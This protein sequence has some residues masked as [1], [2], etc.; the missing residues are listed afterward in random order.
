MRHCK[1][2]S[3]E[4]PSHGGID[5]MTS[6][7]FAPKVYN[8]LHHCATAAAQLKLINWFLE[9]FLRDEIFTKKISDNNPLNTLHSFSIHVSI[10]LK[11]QDL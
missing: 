11:I 10:E 9:P 8:T 7:V 5:H 4:K 6:E 1:I 2:E 3:K